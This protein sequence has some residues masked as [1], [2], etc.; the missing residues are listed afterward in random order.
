[1]NEVLVKSLRKQLLTK[2]M[3]FLIGSGASALAIPIMGDSFYRTS[4]NDS[5]SWEELTNEDKKT[6][7]INLSAR[8]KEVSEKILE[9][10]SS[11]NSTQAI[12]DRFI[13]S[14]VEILSFSNSRQV[15]KNANLFSTNY[16]LFVEKA[17]DRAL[18]KN[19]LV[20]NDG[21]SGYFKR[22]LNSA[23]YNRVVAYKGL[24]DN[25]LN[26]IPSISLIKPHGSMNWK[27]NGEDIQIM[28]SV[29][30]HSVV[31]NP[32]GYE[33]SETFLNNHFHDM[34][35]IFQLELDK[36]QSV[37]ITIGF[38]FQDKHISKMIQRALQNPELL[39]YAF[40]YSDTDREEFMKNLSLDSERFNLKIITPRD[41]FD[42]EV[43]NFTMSDLNEILDFIVLDEEKSDNVK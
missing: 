12:Y 14:I 30:S 18:T 32:T 4:E 10:D 34:L 41:I 24:N 15:V 29:V 7:A 38:S 5:K 37:L 28:P 21:A 35:R 26:E 27:R 42:E 11:V 2:Q 8:V 20:F 16:D 43:K 6:I 1:M 23:N 36:P 13:Q 22:F 3:N 9:E 39:I 40:G 33:N 25:Y 17:A 19:R 31:V